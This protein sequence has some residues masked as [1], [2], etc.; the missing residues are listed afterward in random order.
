MKTTDSWLA[1]LKSIGSRVTHFASTLESFLS[2]YFRP[3]SQSKHRTCSVMYRDGT[4]IQVKLTHWALW[5]TMGHLQVC[6][7]GWVSSLQRWFPTWFLFLFFYP[8]WK[9]SE[10]FFCLRGVDTIIL[11]ALNLTRLCWNRWSFPPVTVEHA[12]VCVN[13]VI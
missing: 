11:S 12:T 2:V 7:Q 1:W 5:P 4:V 3:S 10:H 9:K 13:G 6:S 8:C